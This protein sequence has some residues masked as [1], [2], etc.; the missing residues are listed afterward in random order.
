[1]GRSQN[2][3]WTMGWQPDYNTEAGI[4]AKHILLTVPDARIG[5]L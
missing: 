4:Y 1:M 5:I 2:N 3:P